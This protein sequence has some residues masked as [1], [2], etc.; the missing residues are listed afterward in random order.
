MA[1]MYADRSNYYFLNIDANTVL[2]AGRKGTEARFANHCCAPVS[3][4]SSHLTVECKNRKV[5]RQRGAQDRTICREARNRGRRGNHIWYAALGLRDSADLDYN[6]VW[7]EGAE[8]QKCYCGAENCRGFIGKRKAAPPPP[9]VDLKADKKGKVGKAVVSKVKRVV[10]GKITKVTTKKVKAQVK[11]GKMVK[12]TVITAR[13]KSTSKTTT[14]GLVRKVM[15]IKSPTKAKATALKVIKESKSKEVKNPG[16]VKNNSPASK[17]VKAIIPERKTLLGK[18]KRSDSTTKTAKTPS[19][20]TQK[21]KSAKT[22]K[23]KS[24]KKPDPADRKIAKPRSKK[25]SLESLPEPI[26]QRP[27]YDTVSNPARKR[28]VH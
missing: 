21:D 13:K 17:N 25:A 11:N 12:T 9:K 24:P 16:K 27:V 14:K 7:F 10:N 23:D 15:S 20:K 19:T 22:G 4:S 8:E 6:F 18:R 28:N 5:D 1:T 26:P 3:F 2:D